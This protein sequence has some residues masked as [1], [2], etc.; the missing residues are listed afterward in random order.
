M[1]LM[2]EI[3]HPKSTKL[4]FQLKEKAASH[5]IPPDRLGAGSE[6]ESEPRPDPER[7]LRPPK[8]QLWHFP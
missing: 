3:L 8:T 2:D 7:A 6:H 4:T 5:R 1:L